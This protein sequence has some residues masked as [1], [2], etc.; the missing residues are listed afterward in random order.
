MKTSR[1]HA[2]LEEVVD[3]SPF[4]YTLLSHLYVHSDG[5]DVIDF[6][7]FRPGKE[8]RGRVNSF[9]KNRS[10]AQGTY[11]A[12]PPESRGSYL[13]LRVQE[14]ADD[15]TCPDVASTHDPFPPSKVPSSVAGSAVHGH[16]DASNLVR[17]EDSAEHWWLMCQHDESTAP[18]A[19]QFHHAEGLARYLDSH[20]MHLPTGELYDNEE[21]EDVDEDEG[22]GRTAATKD[23]RAQQEDE[24]TTTAPGTRNGNHPDDVSAAA[25]AEKSPSAGPPLPL[26]KWL[27]VQ[28][29]RTQPHS[30]ERVAR[31]LDML[32]ISQETKDNCLYLSM[33]DSVDINSAA[34][35]EA[36]DT[37]SGYVF[38]NL[39]CTPVIENSDEADAMSEN[40]EKK[41]GFLSH[42]AGAHPRDK[43]TTKNKNKKG[44]APRRHPL[45]NC[46]VME[47]QFEAVR[48]GAPRS[49][50]PDAV[51][52]GIIVFADW[53][54]TI[55]DKPFAEM[56]DLLRMVQLHCAPPELTAARLHSNVLLAPSMRRRFTAPYILSVFL[57]IAVGHH[58]DSITLAQVVDELGDTVFAVKE[59]QRDQDQVVKRI[60][61]VRR[62]FGECG[63]ETARREVVFATLLQPMAAEQFFV[64]DPTIRRELENAQAH[65]WQFQRE[66]SDCR[67]TVAVSNWY[68]NVAIQW[69]L[70]R[71]GNRALRMLLLLTEVSNIMYPIVMVQTLYAMNVPVPFDAGAD[72]PNTSLAPFFVLAAIFVA[73]S[74]LSF[75]ALHTVLR[76]KTFATRFLA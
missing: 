35:G 10:F 67:D 9:L 32:P 37:T 17:I 51:P 70:L 55:H 45:T 26:A 44:T 33:A 46:S 53:M 48:V 14:H 76:R 21:E 20:D 28:V 3:P 40:A 43:E 12:A 34:T 25:A 5:T 7:G 16:D 29:D 47:M 18:F 75:R 60:T 69:F 64:A 71:R 13:H 52:V 66:I 65:L 49:S 31:L 38:L 63:A 4:D 19:R 59:K 22:D 56:D 74:M 15:A 2:T 58:L 41:K 61:A 1:R 39:M 57:Q 23:R 36:S 6:G 27:D 30:A 50:V 68:H 62:C 72:P 8:S 24:A 73:Y 54:F 42:L 11:P